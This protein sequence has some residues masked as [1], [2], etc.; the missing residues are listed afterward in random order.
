MAPSLR[1]TV[2]D[3]GLTGHLA[4][5]LVVPDG[6][7]SSPG[8]IQDELCAPLRRRCIEAAAMPGVGSVVPG[9]GPLAGLVARL[10][11]EAPL[12]LSDGTTAALALLRLARAGAPAERLALGDGA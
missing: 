10:Q 9:G 3:Y 8:P 12:P 2:L 4:G 5:V 6:A 1:Q 7:W 11:A